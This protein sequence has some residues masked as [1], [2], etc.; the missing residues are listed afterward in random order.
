MK[1]TLNIGINDYPGTNMDLSG[2]VN[3]ANDWKEALEAKGFVSTSILDGDASKSNM[4]EA[5]SKIVGD[6]GR[7]DI[8]VITYLGHGTCFPDEDGDEVDG[9][10]EALCPH[11]ITQGQVLTDDE[12]YDIFCERNRGARIIFI[13]DSCHSGTVARSC[14]R[15][16]GVERDIENIPKI[17]FLAPEFYLKDDKVRLSRAKRVENI[18]ARWK[19]RAATVLLSGCKDEE[20]S[21]DAWF[22]GRSNGA[23]TYIALKALKGLPDTATY[24]DWYREIRKTL[25]HI[26]YPQTPQ[27]SGSWRQRAKWRVLA[28]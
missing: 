23:F 26:S 20:Y 4:L 21:Y 27:L 7:D 1:R 24:R 18:R 22:N 14:I 11:D 2:C 10:D 6:T 3:D 16:P 15:M 25:P 8:S 17:R 5:I 19:I 9:R 13:S 28:E 12:L